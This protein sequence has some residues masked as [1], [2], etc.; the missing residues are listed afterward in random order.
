MSEDR[1]CWT[2]RHA[3]LKSSLP[4]TTKHVLLTISCRMNDVGEGCYPSTSTLAEETGLSERAV[5]KHIADAKALGWLRVEQHGFGGQKWKRNQYFPAWPP[6]DCDPD[7][8][9][10]GTD[11]GSG[12][13]STE[14]ETDS[15]EGTDA[16]SAAFGKGTDPGSVGGT[17]PG[18]KKALTQG[19]CNI[20]RD[21]S[22]THSQ[23]RGARRVCVADFFDDLKLDGRNGHVVDHLISELAHLPIRASEHPAAAFSLLAMRDDL[24]I[25]SDKALAKAALVLRGERSV[26][27]SG[28]IVRKAVIGA[29]GPMLTIRQGE[30]GWDAWLAYDTIR[31][32]PTVWI[33]RE[34]E[35]R[36][37]R[38]QPPDLPAPSASA[39]Q[40][41][42]D[43]KL[44]AAGDDG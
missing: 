9:E 25:H 43:W 30:D 24:A 6:V 27:P 32:N 40:P 28:A 20:S 15:D 2:W 10:K 31:G 33:K 3:I 37:Y 16:G 42:A 18:D 39:G 4:S 8:A 29:E 38:R 41:P 36:A 23:T 14:D 7:A 11:P 19:Q 44:R 12:P 26:M 35:R 22:H 5:C 13:Q 34:G 17:D 21:S 1:R